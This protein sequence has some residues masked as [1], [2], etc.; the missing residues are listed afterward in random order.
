MVN[1]REAG[2][3]KRKFFEVKEHAKLRRCQKQRAEE[4]RHR[5][6]GIS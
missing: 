4:L 2:Q 6:R 3:R 5:A 1:Y